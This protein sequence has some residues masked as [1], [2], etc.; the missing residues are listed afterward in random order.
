MMAT[1]D[2]ALTALHVANEVHIAEGGL[3]RAMMLVKDEDDG[4]GG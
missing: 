2:S 1:G 4:L 3:E